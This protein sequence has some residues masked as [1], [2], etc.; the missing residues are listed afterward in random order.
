MGGFIS[1]IWMG[2]G[3]RHLLVP[4][5]SWA[6]SD[7]G[8]RGWPW[9]PRRGCMPRA[10]AGLRPFLPGHLSLLP[11]APERLSGPP[12]PP[13]GRCGS[14]CPGGL[15]AAVEGCWAPV[16][17]AGGGEQS[18]PLCLRAALALEGKRPGA[19]PGAPP[20][21]GWVGRLRDG[22]CWGESLMPLCQPLS[23]GRCPSWWPGSGPRAGGRP[24]P[25]TNCCG[26]EPEGSCPE[27]GPGQGQAEPGGVWLRGLRALDPPG[28]RSPA[29][30]GQKSPRGLAPLPLSAELPRPGARWQ[31]AARSHG[32]VGALTPGL[33]AA[34]FQPLCPGL[35]PAA[36]AA[37]AS[38]K[39]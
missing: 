38:G 24:G 18:R 22:L 13:E 33:L 1:F 36:R 12:G 39:L 23:W 28:L 7:R 20:A 25:G 26:Q 30:G 27:K 16:P 21:L 2:R 3:D 34:Q 32:P 35:Q 31:A 9:D 19:V 14:C 4:A 6:G 29:G 11:W 15:G 8:S 37:Q 5:S 17:R 10:A